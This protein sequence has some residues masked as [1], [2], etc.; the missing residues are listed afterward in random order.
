MCVGEAA[1]FVI[2][3]SGGF[4]GGHDVRF[5][6]VLLALGVDDPGRAVSLHV[7]LKGF[8]SRERFEILG[9]QE[10][11]VAR[12]WRLSVSGV[13]RDRGE[14]FQERDVFYA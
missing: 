8:D 6:N 9:G 3:E 13:G 12:S 11:Q 5:A 2:G 14:V 4:A 10:N 7:G 1:D